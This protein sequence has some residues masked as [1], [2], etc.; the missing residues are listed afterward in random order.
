MKKEL[1]TLRANLE[2][3]YKR[4]ERLYKAHYKASLT[5]E[6]SDSYD[7]MQRL[8]GQLEGIE[9][10]LILLRDALFLIKQKEER[11]GKK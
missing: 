1:I 9:Y 6:D 4:I 8:G 5:D 11:R 7:S 10:S 2:N 3:K